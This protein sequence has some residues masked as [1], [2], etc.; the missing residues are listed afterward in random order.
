MASA[1][2][3]RRLRRNPSGQPESHLVADY[4]T[5]AA[6]RC[7][8]HCRVLFRMV[9]RCWWGS[10]RTVLLG[11]CVC[12]AL[13]RAPALHR[14]GLTEKNEWGWTDILHLDCD[15]C[16][17]D[18]GLQSLERPDWFNRRLDSIGR[19]HRRGFPAETSRRCRTHLVMDA[20]GNLQASSLQSPW[21]GESPE[22]QQCVHRAISS[23]R[24]P[25][26]K[27]ACVLARG[28]RFE[29]DSPTILDVHA[30]SP[31]VPH[32]GRTVRWAFASMTPETVL[33]DVHH[34][35]D[36]DRC[37]RTT[38]GAIGWNVQGADLDRSRM[39]AVLAGIDFKLDFLGLRVLGSIPLGKLL[40]LAKWSTKDVSNSPS[41][42]SEGLDRVFF[43][44]GNTE[45]SLKTRFFL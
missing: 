24:S 38:T 42:V 26:A 18:W 11:E 28:Y 14:Q 37:P 3:I 40:R 23:F 22:L 9:P 43:R 44:K 31:A 8:Q 10:P 19:V 6:S 45:E 35:G 39:D 41:V 25:V 7:H 12:K 34:D 13:A 2:R 29:V 32:Y 27:G 21:A 5:V 1:A 17:P 16:D 30:P 33:M 4:R 36:M 15:R 20:T